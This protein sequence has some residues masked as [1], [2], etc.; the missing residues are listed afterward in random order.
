MAKIILRNPCKAYLAIST[1][2]NVMI[3]K[4]VRRV[5][6]FIIYY[7]QYGAV[8]CGILPGMFLPE[9]QYIKKK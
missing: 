5:L 7:Y 1:P 8:G 2:V 3:S 4:R 9:K 6:D